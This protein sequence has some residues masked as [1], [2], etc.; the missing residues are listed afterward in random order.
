M[1]AKTIVLAFGVVLFFIGILGFFMNPV[2]GLFAVDTMHNLIHVVSGLLAFAL[3]MKSVGGA[4]LFGKTFGI[5][6]AVLAVLGFFMSGGKILDL[7][8]VNAADNVLHAI[9]AL[10]FLFAGFSRTESAAEI[11]IA[12]NSPTTLSQK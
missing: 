3:A 7:L 2:L 1:N 4:K 11:P 9:L 5:I 6:Y 8:M 12:A 10:L